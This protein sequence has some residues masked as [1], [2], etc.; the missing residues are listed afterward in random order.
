MFVVLSKGGWGLIGAKFSMWVCMVGG[1][2][3]SVFFVGDSCSLWVM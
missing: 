1:P 3:G 2:A